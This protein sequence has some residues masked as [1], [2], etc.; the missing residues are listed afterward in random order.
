MK[1][2]QLRYLCEVVERGFNITEAAN[3]LHTSQPGV[4]KQIRL[5]ERELG[6]EILARQGQRITGLT[7][8]GRELVDAAQRLLVDAQELKHMAEN[9]AAPGR[10][11]LTVATTHLHARYPLLPV[12][13][14]F[15]EK[16]PGV[17]LSLFQ[18]PPA[19][20]ADRVVAGLADIGITTGPEQPSAQLVML[21]AYRIHRCL[22]APPGHPLLKLKKPSLA[23]IAA[24][25]LIVY[26]A[27][28]S[29]G[30]TVTRAF[31]RARLRPNIVLSA[32][33]A[34]VIKAYVGAGL[35]VAILQSMAY[36]PRKDT[37]VCGVPVDH[38]IAPSMTYVLLRKGKYL[39]THLLDFVEM[40]SKR[41]TPPLVRAALKKGAAPGT[42]APS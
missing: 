37:E 32:T 2:Q 41:W 21:P 20:I 3:A 8:P 5:L 13:S 9:L 36:D 30:W 38:L 28:F 12:I 31:E 39:T 1:L 7:G 11:S 10:G 18:G 26:D 23:Q 35:G 16:H 6:V 25:P 19:A 42:V 33:D 17:R 27:N 15:V 24:Y 34:D 22:I 40:Y 4:S 29:S 14:R